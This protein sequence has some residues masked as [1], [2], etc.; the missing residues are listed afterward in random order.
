MLSHH[1]LHGFLRPPCYDGVYT[2]GRSNDRPV[3]Y[4]G[5]VFLPRTCLED[6][7]VGRLVPSFTI[8]WSSIRQFHH[9]W[10]RF[11]AKCFL[12]G[13][14]LIVLFADESWYRR[15]IAQAEQPARG[16]RLLRLVGIWQ[17][18][19]HSGYF[20]PVQ[21]SCHRLV[22]VFIKPVIVPTMIY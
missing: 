1:K 19:V 9:R 5:H 12:V 10:N 18:R 8:L 3:L 20:L 17:I 4:Q 7:S 11:M 13:L 21:T 15:D 22:A 6:W 16:S 14:L 2:Y